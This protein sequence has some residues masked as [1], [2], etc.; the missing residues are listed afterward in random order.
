M[1][2][3][4]AKRPSGRINQ[5][6]MHNMK[7]ARLKNR[8]AYGHSLNDMNH[9]TY[10]LRRKVIDIIREANNKGFN[11][12][13]IEVRIV[14]GGENLNCGYA[15]LNQ[16]IIH[17]HD[18]YVTHDMAFLTHLVLHEVVHAVTGFRHDDN[19]PLMCPIVPNNPNITT[20]WVRFAHYLKG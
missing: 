13:R 4:Y 8:T 3:Q 14:S 15:Y 20:A 19:C 17:I 9:N 10:A 16:N 5:Q 11:L 18:K 1:S 12:P 7:T 6:K 2:I